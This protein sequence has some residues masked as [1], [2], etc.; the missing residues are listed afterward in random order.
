VPWTPTTPQPI[1][2]IHRV[3]PRNHYASTSSI[4][5]YSALSRKVQ[6]LA[7]HSQALGAAPSRQPRAA[8]CSWRI[9]STSGINGILL[10]AWGGEWLC[11]YS[12]PGGDVVVVLDLRKVQGCR[13][14]STKEYNPSLPS[15]PFVRPSALMMMITRNFVLYILPQFAN[16]VCGVFQTGF[17]ESLKDMRFQPRDSELR[18]LSNSRRDVVEEAV[19]LSSPFSIMLA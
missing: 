7:E 9:L 10:P 6:H 15:S 3:V 18:L 2:S 17:R 13:R 14:R 5:P 16:S 12:T 1:P 11:A 19:L 8:T 4:Q